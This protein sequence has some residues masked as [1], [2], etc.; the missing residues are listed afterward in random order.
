MN[1]KSLHEDSVWNKVR[2]KIGHGVKGQKSRLTE[3]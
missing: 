3:A 2:Q 1:N